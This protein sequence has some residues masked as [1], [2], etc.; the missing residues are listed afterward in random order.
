MADFTNERLVLSPTPH[1]MFYSRTW[2]NSY[3][4]LKNT[5]AKAHNA[6]ECIITSSGMNAISSLLHAI[7]VENNFE[8]INIVYSNELYC[9]SPR[10]F[11]YVSAHYGNIKLHE[12]NVIDTGYI[13]K[14]FKEYLTNDTVIFHIESCSNPNGLILDFSIL[15][16]L[17][18]LCRKIYIVIDNTWLSHVVFNPFENEH[19]KKVI[20]SIFV[21]TSLTKYYSA[22]TAIGGAIISNNDQIMFR[23]NDWIKC[24]GC[25]VSPHNCD[26]ITKNMANINIRIQKTSD[27]T[28]KIILYLKKHP[29]VHKVIHPLLSDHPSFDLAKSL[30]AKVNGE[31]IGPGV[32]TFHVRGNKK[33]VLKILAS[34]KIISHITSFGG[35]KTRTDPW[36]REVREKNNNN[37]YVMIRLALGYND[38]YDRIVSGL[39]EILDKLE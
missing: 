27:I 7:F 3:E 9:D 38:E 2:S 28:R 1:C 29:K 16:K 36:P 17:A 18:A 33:Q 10:L 24:M 37:K 14:L 6:K 30:F 35:E 26:L 23:T 8:Q 13:I 12:I 20:Q 5:L 22:G 34:A 11:K 32:F 4:E 15:P 19:I 21:V 31:Y 39:D 25:H